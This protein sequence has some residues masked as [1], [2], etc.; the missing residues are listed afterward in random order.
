M[1][2]LADLFAINRPH[3]RRQCVTTGFPVIFPFANAVTVTP[4]TSMQFADDNTLVR[5]S[6]D[7]GG[8]TMVWNVTTGE[9]KAESL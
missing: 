6:A 3:T 9:E 1:L 4:V 2:A 8:K 5:V 7:V